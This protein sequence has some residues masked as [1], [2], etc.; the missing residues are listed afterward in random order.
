MSRPRERN[1][2]VLGTQDAELSR[3]G[4]QH[5]LWSRQAARAWE[6]ARFRPGHHLLDIGCGPG[7]AKT[8]LAQIV[9]V[10]GR[11]LGV[12]ASERFIEHLR[13]RAA[14]IGLPQIEAR[15]GDVLE[16]N[17]PEQSF[18]GAYVRWVLCFVSDPQRVIDGVAPICKPGGGLVGQ[19]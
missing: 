6:A 17:L 12:D 18:D 4:F 1:E 5:R 11:V 10:T 7:F 2:Y 14:A 8:E 3:L 19:D 13:A 16:M 9:G 15:V